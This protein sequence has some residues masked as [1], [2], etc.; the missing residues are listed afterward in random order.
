MKQLNTLD[1]VLLEVIIEDFAKGKTEYN[2]VVGHLK[3]YEEQGFD[4]MK[5]RFQLGNEMGRRYVREL[6]SRDELYIRSLGGYSQ[7]QEGEVKS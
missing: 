5:Q 7:E 6:L 4:T 1:K 3:Y 2:K